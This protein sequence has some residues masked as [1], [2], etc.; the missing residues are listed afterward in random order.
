M[1]GPGTGGGHWTHA[2]SSDA[3]RGATASRAH[4]SVLAG[5]RRRLG[6]LLLLTLSIGSRA[7]DAGAGP[8][9]VP[10]APEPA[11]PRGPCD[12]VVLLDTSSSMDEVFQ[13]A[14]AAVA[15]LVDGTG[16]EDRIALIAFADTARTV[17]PFRRAT[18]AHR[19]RLHT[20]ME[21]LHTAGRFTDLPEALDLAL[22]KYAATPSDA[23]RS[24]F[25]A[26]ITDGRHNPP[27][28][29]HADRYGWL[30]RRYQD[31]GIMHTWS[32]HYVA[33]QARPGKA[34]P[35]L[36]PA[37]DPRDSI[38]RAGDQAHFTAALS[39]LELPLDVRLRDVLGDAMVTPVGAP[40]QPVAVGTRVEPGARLRTVGDGRAVVDLGQAGCI[41]L[42]RSTTIRLM[43]AGYAPTVGR[44]AVS[45][46]VERGRLVTRVP[47]TPAPV[48]FEVHSP[49]LRADVTGTVFLTQVF[50]DAGRTVL[51][52][53]RGVVSVAAAP[54][55]QRLRVPAD[56]MIGVGADPASGGSPKPLSDDLARAWR[57]WEPALADREPLRDLGSR[58]ASLLWD[59]VSVRITDVRPDREYQRRLI[60]DTGA[61][62]EDTLRVAVAGD[63]PEG[64]SLQPTIKPLRSDARRAVV[65]LAVQTSDR[66]G[67]A[68]GAES[69]ARIALQLPFAPADLQ[70]S[71]PVY[72][73]AAPPV[74]ASGLGLRAA[75]VQAALHAAGEHSRMVWWLVILPVAGVVGAGVLALALERVRTPAPLGRLLLR[76]NPVPARWPYTTLDLAAIGRETGTNVISFGSAE[77]NTVVLPGAGVRAHHV[78]LHV[79]GRLRS[80]RRIYLRI[81]PGAYVQINGVTKRAGTLRLADK[82][83]VGIGRFEFQF[84]DTQYYQQIEVA[85]R[86]GDVVRGI[87]HSWDLH[88]SDFI[89]APSVVDLRARTLPERNIYFENV[90]DI[91][92][93]RSHG[94]QSRRARRKRSGPRAV[95]RMVSGRT[96]IGHLRADYTQAATRIYFFPEN[97][98][99]VDYL[100]IERD[101]VAEI[102]LTDA[103]TAQA[104]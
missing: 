26:L 51:G 33:V 75:R 101:A 94:R 13:E 18:R 73:A 54:V 41:G 98:P 36:V 100:I 64:L 104:A 6:C 9:G 7:A 14:R 63:L 47:E 11:K 56:R 48:A 53:V 84:E 42:D 72:L 83:R 99:E 59:G 69:V 61:F 34:A 21:G 49:Q 91:T 16:P 92:V 65:T 62:S 102:V 60:V 43:R 86:G 4:R 35:D 58:F 15:Q 37:L 23:A 3:V 82:M 95:V 89:I 85:L 103:A 68:P 8:E 10:L 46:Y 19:Y 38:M 81:L 17:V 78:E 52:V 50:P 87:L 90:E 70:P 67:L 28:K 74:P 76:H 88:A 77:D 96:H 71:F 25:V 20:A 29:S 24:R 30:L 32:V 93:F 45:V 1:R 22:A 55:P 39:R 5:R 2:A 66:L 31:L 80:N 27:A 44:V 97:R 40:E 57:A 79:V 12:V